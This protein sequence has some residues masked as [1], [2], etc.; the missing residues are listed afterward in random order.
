[1]HSQAGIRIPQ[2]SMQGGGAGG[3]AGGAPGQD[4]EAS[5]SAPHYNMRDFTSKSV[6]TPS[7]DAAAMDGSSAGAPG[8]GPKMWPTAP[9][10][11]PSPAQ[12]KQQQQRG[13]KAPVAAT[14]AQAELAEEHA[15]L[16]TT[17]MPALSSLVRLQTRFFTRLNFL[18]PQLF[19]L[20]ESCVDQVCGCGVLGRGVR[21]MI[22][23]SLARCR[24][25]RAWLALA[26]RACACCWRRLARALTYPR[27]T[28]SRP[29]CPAC[30]R[31]A[32][33]RH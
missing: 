8:A 2:H 5:E 11:A 32:R 6:P 21:M 10:V 17:C 16:R 30:L 20:I 9:H 23:R 18:L 29:P 7:M 3:G 14:A 19:G 31:R 22:Y 25:S 4:L 27:G 28:S 24:R 15:W 13:G 12:L 33:L 26:W 1:M